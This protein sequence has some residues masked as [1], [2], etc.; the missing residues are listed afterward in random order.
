[1]TPA[2]DS[3]WRLFLD[4]SCPQCSTTRTPHRGQMGAL[5]WAIRGFKNRDFGNFG[6]LSPARAQ[7]FVAFAIQLAACDHSRARIGSVRIL[8]RSLISD[9]RQPRLQGCLANQWKTNDPSKR[10]SQPL[11]ISG[12][13]HEV[14]PRKDRRG[15][16][17]LENAG[18][19]PKFTEPEKTF[20][21][22]D[23]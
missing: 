2:G 17:S 7:V 9:S 12:T 8:R 15:G 21:C 10:C 20:L 1:M 6:S 3:D 18:I 19:I 16:D 4:E 14:R 23:L 5:S 22:M 13:N 11:C